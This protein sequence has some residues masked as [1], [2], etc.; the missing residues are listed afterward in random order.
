MTYFTNMKHK[1]YKTKLFDSTI[2]WFGIHYGK[3]LEDIPTE[4]FKYLLDNNI[5]FNGMKSYCVYRQN[6]STK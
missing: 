5:A 1:K 3:K 6:K 4:Y 2:M